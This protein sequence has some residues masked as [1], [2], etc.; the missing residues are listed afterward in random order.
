MVC[1]LILLSH[2]VGKTFGDCGVVP[3]FL[4]QTGQSVRDYEVVIGTYLT[5]L[6]GVFEMRGCA[7]GA[8]SPS[9]AKIRYTS[10]FPARKGCLSMMAQPRRNF[11]GYG[12]TYCTMQCKAG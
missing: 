9:P 4:C 2:A 11:K 6:I 5:Y 12:T 8:R 7:V 10:R 1:F 3:F